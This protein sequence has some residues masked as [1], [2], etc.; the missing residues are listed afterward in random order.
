M[1]TDDEKNKYKQQQHAKVEEL[2]GNV[3]SAEEETVDRPSAG[4]FASE[5]GDFHW[6]HRGSLKPMHAIGQGTYATVYEAASC[7]PLG[8]QVF[9]TDCALNGCALAK[10]NWVVPLC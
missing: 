3:G 7:R 2:R 6:H 9:L 8:L 5:L 4:S 10:S 1:L